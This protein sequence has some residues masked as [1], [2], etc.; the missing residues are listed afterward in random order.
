MKIRLGG[1]LALP[2]EFRLGGS[3]ALPEWTIR[4]CALVL[5]LAVAIFQG[6][7]FEGTIFHAAR[8]GA[9]EWPPVASDAAS[10]RIRET[11]GEATTLE[12]IETPI[13]DA[14]DYL[15]DLHNVEIQFNDR[16]MQEVG[17]GT[18]SPVT[19]NLK[20]ITLAS[21]L[22]RILSEHDLTYTIR[23]EVLLITT[24]DDVL[25]HVY[26]SAYDVEPL[27]GQRE[28]AA[29]IADALRSSMRGDD[30]ARISIT[31]FRTLLIVRHHEVGHA[32]VQ[33][34]L[35]LMGLGLGVAP[36]A[37]KIGDL[38]QPNVLPVRH[39]DASSEPQMPPL[40]GAEEE[41]AEAHG[42][43]QRPSGSPPTVTRPPPQL[44]I[45]ARPARPTGSAAE[46]EPAAPPESTGF[47][48]FG[49]ADADEPAAD[50]GVPGVDDPF[51]EPPPEVETPTPQPKPKPAPEVDDRDPFEE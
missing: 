18:D 44:P 21:A 51:A 26:S 30:D 43:A 14:V 22:R 42:A 50:P 38:A 39:A 35:S 47:D 32:E 33:R 19:A 36:P 34:L 28:S 6:S 12:F 23:D 11:L 20:G 45:P 4:A 27:L 46:T 41:P 13:S 7:I 31:P 16:R 25:N 48:P 8:A 1:S 37:R 3:P 49:N 17:V 9:A 10:E 15:K 5:L 24:P 40:P 2:K 29:A